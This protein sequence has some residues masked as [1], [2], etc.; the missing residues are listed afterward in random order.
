MLI[1]RRLENG[2]KVFMIPAPFMTDTAGVYSDK[3]SYAVRRVDG[4]RTVLTII[5]DSDWINAQERV[6]PVTVG[7]PSDAG[8]KQRNERIPVHE[9]QHICGRRGNFGRN[10]AQR[11][12]LL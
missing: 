1:F 4:D 6:F 12:V 9:R 3:V 2:E 7:S 11:T 8:G 5:A 10:S